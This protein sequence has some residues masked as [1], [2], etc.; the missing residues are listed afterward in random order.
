MGRTDRT[1]T[2]VSG[3]KN[4]ISDTDGF[5]DQ[6]KGTIRLVVE[7]SRVSKDGGTSEAETVL[8]SMTDRACDADS[9]TD[10]S[11]EADINMIYFDSFP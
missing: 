6:P 9:D 4:D 10:T 2:A 7:T 8:T 5:N 3:T 1:C 11:H